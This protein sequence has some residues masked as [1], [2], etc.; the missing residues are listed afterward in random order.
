VAPLARR[1]AARAAAVAAASVPVALGLTG[2]MR[3]LGF[4]ARP[5]GG[6]I[7]GAPGQVVRSVRLLAVDVLRLGNGLFLG[8]PLGVRWAVAVLAALATVAGAGAAAVFV[9][10]TLRRSPAVGPDRTGE[11]PPIPRELWTAYW[12]LSALFVAGAF[13]VT[14]FGVGDPEGSTRYLAPIFYGLVALVPAAAA[15][16]SSRARRL[17]AAG[18][19]VVCLTGIG[20]QADV[21]H[22]TSR[23]PGVLVA[24]DIPGVPDR[25]DRERV[26]L[27]QQSGPILAFLGAEHVSR[28]YSGYWDSHPLTLQ[29]RGTATVLPVSECRAPASTVLCASTLA[30]ASR[31]YRPQEGERSFVLTGPGG[32]LSL[33]SPPSG[34]FGPPA[35]MRRFGRYAV[36][37]YDYDVASRFEPVRP[38][39][40]PAPAGA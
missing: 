12:A 20:G 29:S 18:A 39:N 37:V 27:R 22:G 8:R 33:T 38:P 21:L 19:A 25:I 5:P 34:V 2:V 14:I 28:G 3:A 26:E 9:W 11:A 30:T 40:L 6:G 7:L 24:S 15:A 36:F 1:V 13:A 32:W 31:W 10:R 4:T 16:S 17:A 35:A 23:L